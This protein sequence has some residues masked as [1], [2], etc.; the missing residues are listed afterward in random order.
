MRE[1]GREGGRDGGNEGEGEERERGKHTS[2]HTLTQSLKTQLVYIV[3]PLPMLECLSMRHIF[4]SFSSFCKSVRTQGT[5][6]K[7]MFCAAHY[8]QTYILL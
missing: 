3:H 4:S 2:M 6:V 8:T 7:L 5:T 1:G